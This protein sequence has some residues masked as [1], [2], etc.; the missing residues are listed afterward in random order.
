M[1]RI[2]LFAISII[3]IN[4]CYAWDGY[5]RYST[6]QIEILPGNLAQEGQVIEYYDHTEGKSYMAQII[7]VDYGFPEGTMI[8]LE[9]FET[10]QEKIFIMD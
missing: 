3:T 1:I 8:I 2:V 6:N 5:D 4:P 10:Q 7:D 9:D